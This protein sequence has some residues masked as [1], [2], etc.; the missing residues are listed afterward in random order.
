MN[1]IDMLSILPLEGWLLLVWVLISIIILF[2]FPKINES[3]FYQNKSPAFSYILI[4]G[5]SLCMIFVGIAGAKT[6][7]ELLGSIFV[8][9]V[10]TW[11][12]FG[13]LSFV[14]I[15]PLSMLLEIAGLDLF[16]NK[17]KKDTITVQKEMWKTTKVK[18]KKDKNVTETDYHEA[19]IEDIY[20]FYTYSKIKSKY[21]KSISYLQQSEQWYNK[22]KNHETLAIL[23]KAL[24]LVDNLDGAI[25]QLENNDIKRLL[26]I[27]GDSGNNEDAKY[28]KLNAN[29]RAKQRFLNLKNR[30]FVEG[31]IDRFYV[32]LQGKEYVTENNAF[33]LLPSQSDSNTHHD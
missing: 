33:N 30:G 23:A 25:I 22:I 11:K 5:E 3:K 20:Y 13:I 29:E 12:D 15:V 4:I 2:T 6:T 16:Y 26:F 8:E 28:H 17:I 1:F 19:S 21:E 14:V 18:D 10:P 24:S 7:F 27:T 32:T 31:E 9:F